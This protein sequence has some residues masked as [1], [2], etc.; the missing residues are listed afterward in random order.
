M[1]SFFKLSRIDQFLLTFQWVEYIKKGIVCQ[2]NFWHKILGL[3]GGFSAR[4]LGIL[5]VEMEVLNNL[6]RPFERV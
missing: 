5:G 3:F 1:T 4:F 2:G 6:V